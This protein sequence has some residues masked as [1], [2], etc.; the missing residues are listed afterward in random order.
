MHGPAYGEGPSN[1]AG[2]TVI[3][4][5]DRLASLEV[6]FGVRVALTADRLHLDVSGPQAAVKAAL[7]S[8][9]QH[10]DALITHLRQRESFLSSCR[11]S[12]LH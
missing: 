10:R 9:L 8:L 12:S 4:A 6:Y 7:P 2:D 1:S 3:C 11:L 5:G